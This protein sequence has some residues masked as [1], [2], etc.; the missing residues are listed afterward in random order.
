[1]RGRQFAGLAGLLIA[2][3]GPPEPTAE[4]R[5]LV[6]D[7]LA[8]LDEDLDLRV[9][10]ATS[11]CAGEP[12]PPV[13]RRTAAERARASAADAASRGVQRDVW[14]RFTPAFRASGRVAERAAALEAR[15]AEPDAPSPHAVRDELDELR[16]TLDE[17][18]ATSR[19]AA[20]LE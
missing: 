6:D 13:A 3:G 11:A 8:R 9:S 20:R 16:A 5:R 10:A 4:D 2:C 7:W 1:M 12:V 14:V 18:I 15:C 19:R 17:T